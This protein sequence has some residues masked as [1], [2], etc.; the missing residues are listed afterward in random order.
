VNDYE[1][2]QLMGVGNELLSIIES[3]IDDDGW[4]EQVTL[5]GERLISISCD[6]MEMVEVGETLIKM[7]M[8]E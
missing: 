3:H 1:L 4:K 6:R 5:L 2:K 8:S 7:S